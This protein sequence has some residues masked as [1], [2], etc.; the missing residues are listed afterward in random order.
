MEKETVGHSLWS[1]QAAKDVWVECPFRIQKSTC[2][3][4]EFL[5]IFIRLV[6]RF[7]EEEPRLVA[8]VAR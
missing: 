3:V 8:H 6:E 7:T 4:D 2:D 5:N 1:C